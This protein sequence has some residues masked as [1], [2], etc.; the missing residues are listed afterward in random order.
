MTPP[1]AYTL[2]YPKNFQYVKL[3]DM[4]STL[5]A[6]VSFGPLIQAQSENWPS[7]TLRSNLVGAWTRSADFDQDGD[8]DFLLQAGDSVF[9]Y[10]NLRPG[11]AGHLIDA[12]F[13]NSIY[14]YVDVVD[15]D[16]DGD[17][18]VLKVSGSGGGMDELSWNENVA[19]GS[20]WVKHHIFNPPSIAPVS[21]THLSGQ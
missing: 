19:K 8:P 5:F 18:D 13:I 14:G 10:E 2:S 12:T 11:W 15:L 6:L 9:W 1:C 7:E 20:S 4:L 3:N 21:Y 17:M 16:K